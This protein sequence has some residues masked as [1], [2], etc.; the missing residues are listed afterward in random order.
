MA[1]ALWV[2]LRKRMPSAGL[3]RAE[4]SLPVLGDLFPVLRPRRAPGTSFPTRTG[5]FQGTCQTLAVFGCFPS[6]AGKSGVFAHS[7]GPEGAVLDAATTRPGIVRRFGRAVE[8]TSAYRSERT[9]RLFALPA[10]HG[11]FGGAMAEAV[12]V[13]GTGIQGCPTFAD[14]YLAARAE[15]NLVEL[16][17]HTAVPAIGADRANGG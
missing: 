12:G 10:L 13:K 3:K 1:I 16:T 14:D 4:V 8:A 2:E 15:R 9:K 6:F 7:I 5:H 11:S 17:R